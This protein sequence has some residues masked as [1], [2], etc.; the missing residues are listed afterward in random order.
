MPKIV[1]ETVQ[2]SIINEWKSGGISQ[3]KLAKKY[4]VTRSFVNIIVN[5]RRIQKR[6]CTEVRKYY[7]PITGFYGY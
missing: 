4:N 1:S 2:K 3:G 7:C 5:G 6:K